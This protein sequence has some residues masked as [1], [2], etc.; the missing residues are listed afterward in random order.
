MAW[1][2]R[3]FGRNETRAAGSDY[4]PQHFGMFGPSGYND[5]G[6]QITEANALICSAVWS[7]VSII[8][9]TIS[10]LPVH[11]VRRNGG[12]KQYEHPLYKLLATQPNEF[13][14]PSAF[15]EAFLNNALLYGGAWAVVDR[16]ESG[17]VAA[18]YPLKS[19]DVTPTRRAGVLLFEVRIG[20]KL[21]T[22][23]QDQVVNLLG[24]TMDGVTPLSPVRSG[25]QSLGLSVA[26]ERYAGKAF[27]SAGNLGGIL[28]T[29]PLGKEAMS[30]FIT[31]WREKYTGLDNAFRVAV[32]PDPMKFIATTMKPQE[33]QLV[34][35]R[36]AIVLDICRLWKVP[37]SM[38]GVMDKASYASLEQ[39]NMAFHQQTIL[40]WLVKLEQ[41]FSLVGFLE[42][43]RPELELK[44]NAD[45][46]LRTTTAERYS[47][48]MQGRQG[49]W[50]SINDVRRKEGLP[51]VENGDALLTPL[52]M[53]PVN[54]PNAAAR[55][56]VESTVKR[57]VTKEAKAVQRAAKKYEGQPAELRAWAAAFYRDHRPA[58]KVAGLA[59][60]VTDIANR[61]C[62]DGAK[63]IGSAIDQ[64]LSAD[65]LVQ[66]V[67][68]RAAELTD[69]ILNDGEND[70]RLAA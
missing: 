48:Y 53:A 36:Q 13:M 21:F 54:G 12:E 1:L 14:T 61:H 68:E 10:T 52:N 32:L 69:N 29:P 62:A 67:E 6:V 5:S 31:S 22:F 19:G 59:L 39:Q 26:M 30:D 11:V 37:P 60:D 66:D 49:G 20:S 64:K 18:F 70:E 43:E 2:K 4:L 57:F 65:E 8:S 58:I 3:M 45:A 7:C 51:P 41:A 47:A 56:L 9:Q 15:K 24:W 34:E 55:S 42:R 50:L 35:A 33:G 25:A 28:Q 40:P 44:F 63:L 23:T 38:L 46:L 16:D 27:S 17:S